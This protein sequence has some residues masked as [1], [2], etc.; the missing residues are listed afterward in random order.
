M[1]FLRPIQWYHSHVDPV[2]LDGTFKH[3][4]FFLELYLIE[5]FRFATGMIAEYFQMIS[6]AWKILLIS[7]KI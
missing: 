6:F 3:L 5:R 1:S 7:S 4:S 2:W